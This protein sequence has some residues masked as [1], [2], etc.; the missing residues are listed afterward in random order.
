MKLIISNYPLYKTFQYWYKQFLQK[1]I[2]GNFPITIEAD[3]E[4]INKLHLALK[5]EVQSNL[6][7][8]VDVDD[9]EFELIED[10]DPH[11]IKAQLWFD[12]LPPL[13]QSYVKVLI[14][15]SERH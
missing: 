1:D 9:Y 7:S 14:K 13:E 5:D 12:N 3:R 8:F 10:P 2:S 11:L 15:Q 6:A 4:V